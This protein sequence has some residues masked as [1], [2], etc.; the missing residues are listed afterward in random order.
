MAR[1]TPLRKP[2]CGEGIVSRKP[3]LKSAY[4]F[5]GLLNCFIMCLCWPICAES[6]VKHQ[7][8]KHFK[9]FDGP[10]L[11]CSHLQKGR[12]VKEKQ[13]SIKAAVAVFMVCVK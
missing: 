8:N 7:A 6:A 11:T 10:D 3:G 13:L 2:N 4:D 5:L 1:K 12:P 9:C